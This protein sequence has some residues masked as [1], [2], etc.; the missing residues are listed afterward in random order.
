MK[1][2]HGIKKKILSTYPFG[3]AQVRYNERLLREI[4]VHSIIKNGQYCT[5]NPGKHMMMIQ[6]KSPVSN[7]AL[8]LKV[9]TSMFLQ[10]VKKAALQIKQYQKVFKLHII[11]KNPI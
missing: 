9:I 6:V 5:S 1:I 7:N 3:C 10:V 11:Q 4:D 8:S 2:I